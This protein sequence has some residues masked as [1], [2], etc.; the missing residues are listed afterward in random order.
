MK[1]TCGFRAAQDRV[2]WPKD[3]EAILKEIFTKHIAERRC[4]NPEECTAALPRLPH[5]KGLCR[6]VCEKVNN[7]NITN[8]KRD[9]RNAKA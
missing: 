3:Q 9:A 2:P 4:P 8:R 1:L 7:I 5:C 6:K